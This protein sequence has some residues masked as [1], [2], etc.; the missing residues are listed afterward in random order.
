MIHRLTLVI[1]LLTAASTGTSAQEQPPRPTESLPVPTG[2]YRVGTHDYSWTDST[3][4]ELY[5][6]NPS[7]HRQVLVKTW[8]PAE[9]APDT[10]STIIVACTPAFFDQYL[11]GKPANLLAA[12]SPPYPAATLKAWRE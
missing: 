1:G 3:R 10:G 8:Y 7:D 12:P 6:T 2:P 11:L 4:P 5:P 9:P